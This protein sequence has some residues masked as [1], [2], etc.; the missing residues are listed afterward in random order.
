VVIT[1]RL[2]VYNNAKEAIFDI[3]SK[4]AKEVADDVQ[5]QQYQQWVP[6][7]QGWLKCNVD[8]GILNSGRII[9]GGWCIRDENGQFIRAGTN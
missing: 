6:P 1:P 9:S 2:N 5:E 7:R 8:V 3:C 4:E